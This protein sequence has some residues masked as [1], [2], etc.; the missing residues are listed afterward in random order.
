MDRILL[1]SLLDCPVCFTIPRNKFFS[2]VN[3]HKICESCYIK[4]QPRTRA[5]QLSGRRQCPQA[6]CLYGKPLHRLRDLEIIIE[7]SDLV[8]NRIDK[9]QLKSLLE[10][11]VCLSLPTSKIFAC[12]NGHKI[13]ETC[14][15]KLGTEAGRGRQCPLSRCCY[16][17]APRRLR[18]LEEIID[19][20]DL[21]FNCSRPGC[22]IELRREDLG[23]HE[24]KCE[25]REVPCPDTMCRR[26]ILFRN[27]EK[28]IKENHTNMKKLSRSIFYPA[29]SK[30]CS[31]Y[32][33]KD[34]ILF[35]WSDYN[36]IQ[37]YPQFLK[38][39]GFWYFWVKIKDDPEAAAKFGFSA[40]IE[41][42]VTGLK[43]ECSSAR[44][45]PVDSSV[46]EIIK[47]G[48]CLVMNSGNI[49]NVKMEV[50]GSLRY[51]GKVKISFS[52]GQ[53]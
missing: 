42:P 26:R 20:S 28:C 5:A 10:C 27:I 31:R 32:D 30:E 21:A 13:C 34:W 50:K 29:L 4:L 52:V 17:K 18:D 49:E 15:E 14:F 35:S 41:N 19:K 16:D 43:L 44:V 46:D 23:N 24:I 25:F 45:S 39:D 48:D 47:S 22:D 7:K 6:R 8:L 38:R 9:A 2:C 3:E 37:F 1:K 33:S 11:P 12:I 40:T 36:G 53:I 51:S